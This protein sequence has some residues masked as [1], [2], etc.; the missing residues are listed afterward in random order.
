MFSDPKNASRRTRDLPQRAVEAL[1][2]HHKHQLKEK[3]LGQAHT[4]SQISFSLHVR[5]PR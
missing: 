3:S 1:R 5:V 4:K 2:I